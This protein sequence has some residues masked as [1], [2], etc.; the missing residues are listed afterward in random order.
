METITENPKLINA[1]AVFNYINDKAKFYNNKWNRA[2]KMETIDK[3]F[4]T[5]KMYR[6]F[7]YRATKLILSL[8]RAEKFGDGRQW[9]EMDGK[10]FKEFR[11]EIKKERRLKFEQNYRVHLHFMSESLR[12]DYGTFNCDNCKRE[13]YHSPSTIYKGSEKKHSNC[14]GH[15]VNNLMNWNKQDEVY[16]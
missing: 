14:C 6:D 10:R 4:E 11:A 2:R 12:A 13:F 7:S 5:Y 16:Y 3:H 8:R 1:I 9:F 15:C